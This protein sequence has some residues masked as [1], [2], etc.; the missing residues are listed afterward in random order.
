M[1]DFVDAGMFQVDVDYEHVRPRV[2]FTMIDDLDSIFGANFFSAPVPLFP[3]VHVY[4]VYLTTRPGY[5]PSYVMRLPTNI[6]TLGLPNCSTSVQWLTFCTGDAAAPAAILAM[7]FETSALEAEVQ[8]RVGELVQW[9]QRIT[10]YSE[11][12]K[13]YD[14]SPNVVSVLCCKDRPLLEAPLFIDTHGLPNWRIPL[15]SFRA[16]ATF[17]FQADIST[18]VTSV[19]TTSYMPPDVQYVLANLHGHALHSLFQCVER[20]HM[21]KRPPTPTT[22]AVLLAEGDVV[23]YLDADGA[24]L[25]YAKVVGTDVREGSSYWLQL[26]NAEQPECFA[27]FNLADQVLESPLQ[28]LQAFSPA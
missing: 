27:K 23:V 26:D 16:D 5:S 3:D 11:L 22:Q 21:E 10:I 17:L 4:H 28:V 25:V 7:T 20:K 9:L 12:L 19:D 15:T 6:S 2:D 14:A 1:C 18:C 24:S 13:L 8:E